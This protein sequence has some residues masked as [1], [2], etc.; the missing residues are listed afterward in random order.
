M[1]E[2]IARLT[3]ADV[4]GVSR[5]AVVAHIQRVALGQLEGKI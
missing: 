2:K 1:R 5:E 3:R 4:T